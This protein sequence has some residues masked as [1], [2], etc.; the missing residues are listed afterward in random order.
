MQAQICQWGNGNAIRLSK[1]IMDTLGFKTNDVLD[2]SIENNSV[3]LRKPFVHKTLE[4][5]VSES[6]LPLTSFGEYDFGEQKG[7]EIW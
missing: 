3:I 7:M 2:I 6:G 5:R 1:S 4:Q